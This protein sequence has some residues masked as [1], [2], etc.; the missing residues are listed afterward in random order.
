MEATNMGIESINNQPTRG[1]DGIGDQAAV[2][3]AERQRRDGRRCL[4]ER[5]DDAV[6]QALV[7]LGLLDDGR[8]DAGGIGG[9]L[10]DL[11]VDVAEPEMLRHAA[12]DAVPTRSSRM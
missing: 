5:V 12:A 4:V 8:V 11:V 7:M 3:R 6:D 1:T 10:N 2:Q 9:A